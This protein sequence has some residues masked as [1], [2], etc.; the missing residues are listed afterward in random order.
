VET[1]SISE[2]HAQGLA[3]IEFEEVAAPIRKLGLLRILTLDTSPY[4]TWA[5]VWAIRV[6]QEA[7]DVGDDPEAALWTYYEAI[8][9]MP[10]E[11]VA[12]S[13]L[14]DRRL[15]GQPDDT[16]INCAGLGSGDLFTTCR[17]CHGTGYAP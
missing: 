5:P 13:M 3:R 10:E 6:V 1:L 12:D 8:R 2:A 9:D 16:C 11:Q 14:G 15:I 7:L 4:C 17:Y